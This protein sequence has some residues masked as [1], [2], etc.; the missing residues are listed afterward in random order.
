VV[1][2]TPR[3]LYLQGRIT[4]YQWDRRLGGPQSRSSSELYYYL[5]SIKLSF[6]YILILSCGLRLGHLSGHSSRI[7]PIKIRYIFL[8]IPTEIISTRLNLHVLK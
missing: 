2:Y 8:F 3:P 5:K 6:G 4:W 1:S 7:L